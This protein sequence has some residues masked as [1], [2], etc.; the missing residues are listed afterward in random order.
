M[1]LEDVMRSLIA[2][3]VEEE[4]DGGPPLL[5]KAAV[6]PTGHLFLVWLLRCWDLLPC[7]PQLEAVLLAHLQ[8]IKEDHIGCIVIKAQAGYL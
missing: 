6:H 3:L 5:V 8:Q 7:K 4:G 2:K 1:A